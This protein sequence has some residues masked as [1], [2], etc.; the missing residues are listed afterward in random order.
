MLVTSDLGS[1]RWID[2][3]LSKN[4]CFQVIVCQV[5]IFDLQIREFCWNYRRLSLWR[6]HCHSWGVHGNLITFHF[7]RT[8]W[9]PARRARQIAVFEVFITLSPCCCW[10]VER[11]QPFSVRLVCNHNYLCALEWWLLNTCHQCLRACV[12]LKDLDHQ[13]W[14]EVLIIHLSPSVGADFSP[15]M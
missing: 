3:L 1:S 14:G 15:L 13:T 12:R 4:W 11:I 9:I 10:A 5:L 2:C 6:V 7:S 8:I